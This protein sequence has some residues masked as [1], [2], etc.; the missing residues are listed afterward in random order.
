[1]KWLQILAESAG[2]DAAIIGPDGTTLSYAD[3]FHK[4]TEAAEQLSEIGIDA[5]DRVICMP[6]SDVDGTVRTLAA[7]SIAGCAVI[8]PLS[9][10]AEVERVATAL[11][12]TA[13][14]AADDIAD[15]AR[16]LGTRLGIPVITADRARPGGALSTGRLVDRPPGPRRA[17][18]TGIILS[19]S[20]TTAS[21]KFVPLSWPTM[22]AA[23]GATA[24][25]YRLTRTDRRLNIMPIFHIQGLVGSVL[26]T[27]VSG[28]SILLVPSFDPK[29]ILGLLR[30]TGTTWF[31][32]TPPM[33]TEIMDAWPG[34]PV[35]HSLRFVRVGS[36]AL[37][38]PLRERLAA[39]YGVPVVE[40]YGMTEAHQIAS[41]PL[42]GDG[43][44]GLLPTGSQV[45]IRTE[46]GIM[47]VPQVRGEIVVRGE[48]VADRYL[49]AADVEQLAFRDGWFHTGDE[50]ELR[51]DGSVKITG[52]L[53]EL[54]DRGG[55]KISP[56]E[57]EEVLLSHGDI[58]EVAVVG[59]SDDALGQQ[60]AAAV[61][62]RPGVRTS[63]TDLLAFARSRLAPYKLP[64]QIA[65]VAHLPRTASGKVTRA[66]VAAELASMRGSRADRG[67]RP[68]ARRAADPE[69]RQVPRL[70]AIHAALTGLWSSVLGRPVGLDDDFIM[71]GGESI[72]AVELLQDVAAVFSV[73]ISLISM[74][75]DAYTIRRMGDHIDRH[76]VAT[77]SAFFP[78]PLPAAQVSEDPS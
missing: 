75:D 31:S 76:R 36:S 17:D 45:A 30:D 2:Q 8:N 13:I 10:G 71:L 21:G 5:S 47:T 59:L 32:A 52:R 56:A 11:R 7:A 70:S 28:G 29:E 54:I 39:F 64:R 61:V 18:W 41:T 15:T 72:S 16:A 14:L 51:P 67:P 55:E 12:P 20:G 24:S 23:A 62:L 74:F 53:K 27:L 78:S 46:S 9:T 77:T 40:S 37:P 26:S 65:F 44:R 57:V 50:G 38:R 60:V 68:R 1:M 69:Q 58:A 3:L 66:A 43:T 48:N 63:E 35:Q 4:A 6:A 49:A 42:D 73:R 22:L 25:A 19:T 33:H 34:G